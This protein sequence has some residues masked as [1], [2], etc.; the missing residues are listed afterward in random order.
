MICSPYAGTLPPPVWTR[1]LENDDF[2]PDDT[3]SLAGEVAVG[4]PAVGHV[5]TDG[6]YDWVKFPAEAGKKYLIL[7]TGYL[8]INLGLYDTD[9]TSILVACSTKEPN[10]PQDDNVSTGIVFDCKATGTYYCCVSSAGGGWFGSALAN[11]G[12]YKVGVSETTSLTPTPLF[13]KMLKTGQSRR[14]HMKPLWR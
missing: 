2:E 1:A 11:E 13:T 4:A 7:I 10:L 12:Y 14:L 5:L 3:S 9:E 6:E 8:N